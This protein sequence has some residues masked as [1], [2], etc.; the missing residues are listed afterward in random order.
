MMQECDRKLE[1]Y[2]ASLPPRILDTP[3]QPEDAQAARPKKK[4]KKTKKPSGNQ[5]HLDLKTD[6]L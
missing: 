2:L 1:G 6:G 5:P 4:A 3:A